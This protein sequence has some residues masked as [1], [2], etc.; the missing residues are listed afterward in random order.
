MP[1][2]TEGQLPAI[3]YQSAASVGNAEEYTGIQNCVE[4]FRIVDPVAKLFIMIVDTGLYRLAL[5]HDRNSNPRIDENKP[6]YMHN[7]GHLMEFSDLV[8]RID[9]QLTIPTEGQ[10]PTGFCRDLSDL[11]AAKSNANHMALGDRLDFKDPQF[12]S[13]AGDLGL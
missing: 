8:K 1:D 10:F 6:V 3:L 2:D 9:L 4:A 7:R 11:P 5:V 12:S 13:N